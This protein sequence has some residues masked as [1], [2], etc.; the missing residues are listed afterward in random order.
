MNLQIAQLFSTHFLATETTLDPGIQDEFSN[1]NEE[2]RA[3]S[4]SFI[5]SFHSLLRRL[6][7]YLT[8]GFSYPLQE[9]G[10]M[11]TNTAS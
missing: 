6:E 2:R 4:I 7:F 11:E 1:K 10:G 8:N 5:V 3:A 9:K